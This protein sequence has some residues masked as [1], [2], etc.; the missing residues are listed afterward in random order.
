MASPTPD[1]ERHVAEHD[2]PPGIAAGQP[3]GAVLSRHVVHG[4]ADLGCFGTRHHLVAT[5]WVGP[6]G[7]ETGTDGVDAD[8][9]PSCGRAVSEPPVDPCLGGMQDRCDLATLCQVPAV[10]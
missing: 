10:R 2:L 3:T 8:L 6:S 9:P 5:A 1:V 7:E 4:G